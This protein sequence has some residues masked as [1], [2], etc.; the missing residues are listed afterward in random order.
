MPAREQRVKQTKARVGDILH[1]VLN[2]S[3]SG[4]LGFVGA[5]CN[6]LLRHGGLRNL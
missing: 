1:D 6:Q 4:V 3:E 5:M 2:S